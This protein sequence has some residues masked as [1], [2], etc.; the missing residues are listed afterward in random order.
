MRVYLRAFETE[1]Y[2]VINKWRNDDEVQSLTSGNKYFVSS[3]MEKQWVEGKIYDNSKEIYLAICLKETDE[4]I[5]YTGLR[6]IDWRNRKVEWMA[7][8]IGD[9][10]HRNKG[11][12][13]EATLL[14]LDYVFCEL[15]IHKLSG[16]SLKTNLASIQLFGKLGFIQEGIL[17]DFVFKA[18]SYHDNIIFTILEDEYKELKERYR[19][20]FSPVSR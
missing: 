5:G 3:A 19:E 13:T 4:M 17:R 10:P 6:D 15:G 8:V 9:R 18:N 11:Y 16:Y 1:D 7:L 20:K 12:A 2:K 14:L